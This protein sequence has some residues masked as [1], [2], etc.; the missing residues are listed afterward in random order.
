MSC[1]VLTP[2]SP[3]DNIPSLCSVADLRLTEHYEL[4]YRLTATKALTT[5][6]D[7]DETAARRWTSYY[8]TVCRADFTSRLLAFA[9]LADLAHRLAELPDP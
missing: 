8:C 6:V 5:P 3:W 1:A 2:P 4:D 9:H 7:G